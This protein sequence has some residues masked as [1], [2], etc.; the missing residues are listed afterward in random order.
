MATLETVTPVER[1]FRSHPSSLYQV[2]QFVRAQSEAGH[3]SQ[4]TTDDLLLAVSEACVNAVLHSQSRTVRVSWRQAGG[5][6]EVTVADE[7]VFQRRLPMPELDGPSGRG[8]LLMMAVMDE[9][10]IHEGSARSPGTQ[11]RLRK[12][13]HLD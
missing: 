2:R 5:C 6:A 10:T 8:I 1:N 4:E 11:V 13:E 12:C 3:L 7:G 9:V